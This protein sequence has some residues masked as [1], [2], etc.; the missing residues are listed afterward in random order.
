[1]NKFKSTLL[2]TTLIICTASAFAAPADKGRPI[3]HNNE[4][5]GLMGPSPVPP[6]YLILQQ[7]DSPNETLNNA[8]KNLPA[9]EKGKRYE[10]NWK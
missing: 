1:M 10:I 7:P 9:L 4:R 6:L 8:V 3:C 5:P 2:A